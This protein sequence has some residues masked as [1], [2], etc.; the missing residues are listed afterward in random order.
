MKKL[1]EGVRVIDFGNNIAGPLSGTMLADFGADVIKVEKPVLGDDSR[2]FS[3]VIDGKSITYLWLNR[4]KRSVV[5]DVKNPEGKRLFKELLK[6]ADVLIESSR[7]G[8]MARLGLSWE[9]LHAEFPQLIMYSASAFGQN[10]PY[11]D[12]PGYDMIAQ[13][14]SG[15]IETNGYPDLP[16]CR[17]GPA[18][19]DYVCAHNGFGAIAA[20]LYYRDHS[21]DHEGQHIDISLADCGMAINDYFHSAVLDPATH[22]SGNHHVMM[23]P[24]GV[25]NANGS[26]ITIG[27]LSPKLWAGLCELIGKPEWADASEFDTSG[28]RGMP[29]NRQMIITAIEAWLSNFSDMSEPEKIM[30]DAGIPCA[31]STKLKDLKDDPHF[32]ERKMIVDFPLPQLTSR[33]SMPMR[34][35]HIHMSATPAEIKPGPD[36]NE[37]ADE[38]FRKEMGLSDAQMSDLIAAGA[39]GKHYEQ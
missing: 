17:I 21:E 12:L 19:C 22:R 1:F 23:A 39:F 35:S 37:H 29:E 16:P 3:P 6:T 18:I 27:A 5:L 2:G 14:V 26:S 24:Y 4:G 28:K 10:G 7:P 33:K 32:R 31:K 30:R 36:L 15:L 13:A 20:A 8:V 11:R 34:G 9:E 25:F 38:I